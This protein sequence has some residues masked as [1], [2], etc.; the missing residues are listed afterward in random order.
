MASIFMKNLLRPRPGREPHQDV[1][2][3]SRGR[4][5]VVLK[6]QCQSEA[7]SPGLRGPNGAPP[8]PRSR[9]IVAWCRQLDLVDPP[10]GLPEA[11]PVAPRTVRHA[12]SASGQARCH[13]GHGNRFLGRRQR[14]SQPVRCGTAALY[15]V[16]LAPFPDRLLRDP[17]ALR[18]DPRGLVARLDQSPDLRRR[19]C[20]L[21]KRNQHGR[22]PFQISPR[23][24]RA[25]N[26]ADRRGSM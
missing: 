2:G 24:D 17:V 16:A 23:I 7:R 1:E 25:M 3:P 14:G 4:P 5:D 19:R 8:R 6:S 21:V 12:A 26:R 18:H 9:C 10:R 11:F 13:Q 15:A 20:L 22:T